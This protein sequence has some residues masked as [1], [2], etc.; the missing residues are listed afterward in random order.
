M[1][2]YSDID[3]MNKTANKSV[4]NYDDVIKKIYK[5]HILIYGTF[6]FGYDNDSPDIFEK[7]L[8]FAVKNH[9]EQLRLLMWDFFPEETKSLHQSNE[10]NHF[11]K[12]K[13][14]ENFRLKPDSFD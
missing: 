8:E 12:Q 10:Y 5:H 9:L 4:T 14:F 7:T 6:V 1:I 3:K 2:D 11:L 13:S